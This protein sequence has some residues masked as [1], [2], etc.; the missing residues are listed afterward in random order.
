MM[1]ITIRRLSAVAILGLG[2]GMLFVPTAQANFVFSFSVS[3]ASI[4]TGG[5]AVLDLNVMGGALVPGG[6]DSLIESVDVIFSSGDG[7]S[8]HLTAAPFALVNNGVGTIT[9]RD[10]QHQFTYT[11][12]G[13]FSP[14]VTGSVNEA[15]PTAA[16]VAHILQ[17][18]DLTSTLQVNSVTASVPEASTWAMLLIGF[19]GIGFASYRKRR[20]YTLIERAVI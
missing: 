5:T 12:A 19:A 2:I 3:P 13:V 15:E 14:E 1:Q 4:N 7:Q 18:V 6:I 16:S 20:Q 11:T 17:S 9:S 8:F 10:F